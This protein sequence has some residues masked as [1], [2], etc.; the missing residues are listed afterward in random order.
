M[1]CLLKKEIMAICYGMYPRQSYS[2]NYPT[3]IKPIKLKII[4]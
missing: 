3:T 4:E 1:A 2:I